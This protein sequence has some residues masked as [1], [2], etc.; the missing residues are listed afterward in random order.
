[1][2][3]YETGDPSAWAEDPTPGP[4]LE[5]NPP[6]TPGYDSEDQDHPAYTR[7]Q[8]VPKASQRAAVERKA[9]V[10]IKVATAILGKK[11]SALQ[12][13]RQALDLMDLSDEALNR[14]AGK[15]SAPV[16]AAKAPVK[17]AKAP[18]RKRAFE[19]ELLADEDMF[20]DDTEIAADFD[21]GFVDVEEDFVGEEDFVDG[22]DFVDVEEDF[23]D[24]GFDMLAAEDEDAEEVCS[25]C[26]KNASKFAK[27]QNTV[28][29]LSS[30]VAALSAQ[31]PDNQGFEEVQ[32]IA[33]KSEVQERTAFLKR[34]ASWDKDQDGLLFRSDWQGP[35]SMFAFIDRDKDGIISLKEAGSL[36]PVAA[37]DDADEGE[38]KGEGK[39]DD[40][41]GKK[42]PPFTSEDGG[43][44]AKKVPAKKPA[45]KAAEVVAEEEEE[46]EDEEVVAEDESEDE[47][48][49]VTAE[50]ESEDEDSDDS[51]EESDEDEDSDEEESD[52][53][54]VTAEEEEEEEVE[55]AKE[56]RARKAKAA[57]AKAAKAP[58][59][60]AKKS[61]SA[62]EVSFGG[63][64]DVMAEEDEDEELSELLA[65]EFEE[66][67]TAKK[68]NQRPQVRK[69]STGVKALG[70][71]VRVAS[72][73]DDLESLWE[74]APDVSAYFGMK[75]RR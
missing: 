17:A 21:D 3:Q 13:E 5:G 35:R 55:T 30:K 32:P 54:E 65:E 70:S 49:E 10:A 63:R 62:F 47:D 23:A 27:L 2:H 69:A 53:E 28:A 9:A 75:P 6:A 52:D 48:E 66:V 44:K 34:L 7:R 57:K 14:M 71:L 12:I 4:Y 46:S 72:G 24:D 50:D 41:G 39:D 51:E 58:A 8:R 22:D 15:K 29:R 67:R 18:V 40:F 43:K 1:M 45:K 73:G 19:D 26:A 36:F 16:K 20:L 61:K 42:A 59:K 60:K 56:A 33:K 38:D 68:T 11:A 64:A 37:D 31:L 25:T 74:N